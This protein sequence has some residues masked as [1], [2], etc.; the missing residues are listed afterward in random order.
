MDLLKRLSRNPETAPVLSSANNFRR[1]SQNAMTSTA[2]RSVDKSVESFDQQSRRK[3]E[4][5][6]SPSEI[7]P[8]SSVTGGLRRSKIGQGPRQSL[9]G[10]MK[11][12]SVEI[13]ASIESNG[14]SLHKARK[15][16]VKRQSGITVGDK[17]HYVSTHCNYRTEMAALKMATSKESCSC[18]R[19]L[20]A[21]ISIYI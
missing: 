1:F 10:S 11:A 19:S 5:G 4:I 17:A 2:T 20:L 13:I 16:S 18:I 6:H 14:K 12:S 21:Q 3:T 15:Q 7:G 9:V 8:S